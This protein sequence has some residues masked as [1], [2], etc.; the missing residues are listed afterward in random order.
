MQITLDQ[1]SRVVV[2]KALRD[3]FALKPGDHLEVTVEA[4]GIRLRPAAPA[5]PLADESGILVCSSEVP[6]SAR[7]VGAFLHE[8]RGARSSELGGL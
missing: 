3:R 6:P 1:M 2:P 7:D 4:D 8:Q 5:S